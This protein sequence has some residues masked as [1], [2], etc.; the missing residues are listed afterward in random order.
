[1]S[2]RCRPYFL[3]RELTVVIV[4]AVYIPPDTNASAVLSLLL[5]AINEQQ[6]AHPDGVHIIA[7]DFNRTNLKTI[8]RKFHQRV[9]CPTRGERTLDHV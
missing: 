9:K 1:M 6:R 2:V 5:N 7:A 3:P 4:T 8:L